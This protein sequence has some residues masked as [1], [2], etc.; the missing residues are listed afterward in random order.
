MK[1]VLLVALTL[2]VA[3]AIAPAA[4]QERTAIPV[5]LD[6]S[7]SRFTTGPI[8]RALAREANRP[9]TDPA[10]VELQRSGESVY[11]GWSTV[12]ELRPGTKIVVTSADGEPRTRHVIW[13]GEAD[14]TVLNVEHPAWS[15]S[16]RHELLEASSTNP[17]CFAANRR[18]AGQHVRVGPDGVFVAY[19]KVAELDEVFETIGRSEVREVRSRVRTR[20]SVPGAI[21]GAVGGF[22][23]GSIA[24]PYFAFKPCGHS[25]SGERAMIGLSLVGIPAAAAFLAYRGLAR[26]TSEVVYRKP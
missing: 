23:L 12:R 26:T 4:A 13:A 16:G 8:A 15:A 19:Q 9:A 21:G 25:C 3:V 7:A 20:G 5:S 10:L 14:I 2:G 24:A 1:P 6:T 22:L 18:F 17:E 11:S